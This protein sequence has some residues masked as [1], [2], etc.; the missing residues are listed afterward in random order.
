MDF[1]SLYPNIIVRH[2]VDD[3]G[4]AVSSDGDSDYETDSDSE[5][6]YEYEY[7]HELLFDYSTVEPW[8][9][10]DRSRLVELDDC[11]F[12]LSYQLPELAR[13]GDELQYAKLSKWRRMLR[14]SIY[15]EGNL[16]SVKQTVSLA[17]A[18]SLGDRLLLAG[19]IYSVCIP[20]RDLLGAEDPAGAIAA[21]NYARHVYT[22]VQKR[23]LRGQGPAPFYDSL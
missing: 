13:E 14:V 5:Y 18:A 6:E 7:E 4:G 10:A 20:Y 16:E 23:W 9:G 17:Q 15:T 3:R 2:D 11:A 21:R 19:L 12:A 22:Q 8:K 1:A